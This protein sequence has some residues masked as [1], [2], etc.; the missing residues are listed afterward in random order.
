MNQAD[1]Q[2]WVLPAEIIERI[3][4]FTAILAEV[5]PPTIDETC[6]RYQQTYRSTAELELN[7]TT[8]EQIA[9]AYQMVVAN[10]P[11]WDHAEKLETFKTILLLTMG[12]E[13]LSAISQIDHEDIDEISEA[14][15]QTVFRNMQKWS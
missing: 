9:A 4:A 13:D 14:F 12:M 2:P 10:H 7:L 3:K 6:Q 11:E 5:N 15:T 8:W 1:D